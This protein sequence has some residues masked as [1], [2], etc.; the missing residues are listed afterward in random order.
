MA[1]APASVLYRSA[2]Q[3]DIRAQGQPMPFFPLPSECPIQLAAYA[4]DCDFSVHNSTFGSS[5]PYPKNKI[6][7]AFCSDLTDSNA[8]LTAYGQPKNQGGNLLAFNAL[9]HRVPASWDDPKQI[10]FT[11]PD[12]PGLLG[13]QYTRT[14]FTDAVNARVRRDYYVVD[15][16]G[17]LGT[18]PTS[19]GGVVTT[20]SVTDSAGVQVKRVYSS[21]D[22]PIVAKTN[23]VTVFSGAPQPSTRVNSL[24]KAGGDTIGST[25]WL[26]TCPTRDNYINWIARAKN[27]G[28]NST[29][30]DG[31]YANQ[32]VSTIGQFVIQDSYLENYAGNIITRITTYILAK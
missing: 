3:T 24:I 25:G 31:T 9:F 2:A 14:P 27:Y 15:P 26:E 1:S 7:S 4:F 19:G 13:G 18:A 21:I 5:A 8:I 12:F 17:V 16:D 20:S 29:V 6:A 30:W 11:F 23:F 10:S 22:I 28:W 32:A